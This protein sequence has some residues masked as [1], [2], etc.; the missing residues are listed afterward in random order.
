M[1]LHDWVSLMLG[2]A[3]FGLAAWRRFEIIFS[4]GHVTR[5][6]PSEF[7][8]FG[9]LTQPP[10][11]EPEKDAGEMLRN[12]H[13]YAGAHVLNQGQDVDEAVLADQEANGYTGEASL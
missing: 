8:G 2:G 1:A 7:G 13:H 6:G 3:G 4:G 11:H 9:G 12:Y 10:P 5:P